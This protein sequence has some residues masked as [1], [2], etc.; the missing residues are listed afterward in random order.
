MNCY[1]RLSEEIR[2][3]VDEFASKY[4]MTGSEYIEQL[5]STSNYFTLT[6]S[7][8]I[9]LSSFADIYELSKVTTLFK[10]S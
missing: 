9:F 7:T 3:Q 10:E 4:P 5:K 6:F 8:I 2:T 1:E